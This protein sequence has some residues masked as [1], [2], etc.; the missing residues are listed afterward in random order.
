MNSDNI[1]E[2]KNL[3]KSFKD[4]HAVRDLS[5]CVRKG[6]LAQVRV[7]LFRSFAINLKK[8]AEPCI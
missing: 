7:R 2:I 4:V 5:F 6:E 8:T 3:N 1:I